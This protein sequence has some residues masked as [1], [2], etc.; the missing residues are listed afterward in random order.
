M[1]D[2]SNRYILASPLPPFVKDKA[3][4]IVPLLPSLVPPQR[5]YGARSALRS[6]NSFVAVVASITNTSLRPDAGRCA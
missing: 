4:E 5:R 1:D 3:E 6:R 2:P